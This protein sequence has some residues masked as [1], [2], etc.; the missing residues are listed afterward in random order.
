MRNNNGKNACTGCCPISKKGFK[1]GM[2]FGVTNAIFLLALGWAG[3]LW[4]YGRVVIEQSASIYHGFGASFWGGIIGALWGLLFGFIYG[5]IFG[6]VANYVSQCC[7][8]SCSMDN[9][10]KK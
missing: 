10:C 7:C 2:A 6:V 8:K 5:Y 4:G 9:S 3:W 1:F